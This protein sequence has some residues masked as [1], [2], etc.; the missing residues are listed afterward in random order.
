[1]RLELQ[2]R[3]DRAVSTIEDNK[4]LIRRYTREVFDEGNLAAVDEYL[5]PDLSRDAPHAAGVQA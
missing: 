1:M 2:S 4:E 5:A 3:L